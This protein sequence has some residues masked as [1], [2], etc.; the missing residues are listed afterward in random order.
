MIVILAIGGIV[1]LATFR[2]QVA[3][4]LADV[5]VAL[6]TLDQSYYVAVPGAGYD[7]MVP[8]DINLYPGDSQGYT[9]SSYEDVP[10][11]FPVGDGPAGMTFTTAAVASEKVVGVSDGDSNN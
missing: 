3:Q 6:E 1:G 2:D 10:T 7:P 4:E 11:V 8:F 5:G 9:V